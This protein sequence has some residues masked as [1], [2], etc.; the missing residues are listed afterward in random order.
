[1]LYCSR[2][3]E[4]GIITIISGNI[5]V[6]IDREDNSRCI[7]NIARGAWN[8]MCVVDIMRPKEVCKQ[9][10]SMLTTNVQ[11]EN[12]VSKLITFALWHKRIGHSNQ[13]IIESMIRSQP[14]GLKTN[15]EPKTSSSEI[16]V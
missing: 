2:L 16:C 6:L 8:W 3:D 10:L 15:L 13:S 5:C 7:G 4:K 9:S 14:F 1:M 12:E 11:T